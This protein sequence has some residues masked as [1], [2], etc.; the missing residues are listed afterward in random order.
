MTDN[1]NLPAQVDGAAVVTDVVRRQLPTLADVVPA[2]FNE[3]RFGRLVVSAA[4]A[5]PQLMECF[6]TEAG[7]TS[8]A[9]AAIQ[10]AA[11]GLEP[12]TPLQEA[13]LLPQRNKDVQECRLQIGYKGL[14]KLARNNPDVKEIYAKVVYAND[15]FDYVYGLNPTLTHKPTKGDKGKLKFAYGVVK[16]HSGG[17]DFVVLDEADIAKRKE[18]SR[19]SSSPSSPW[20]KWEAEMW[21][22]SAL[23]RVL[24]TAVSSPDLAQALA[25]DEQRLA[26]NN[27]TIVAALDA[28]S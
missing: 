28:G 10:A 4:K 9:L 19:G 18:A 1:N 22:K 21:Q 27:G 6:A 7:Q 3:K 2:N 24:A 16:F 25:V 20:Q 17:A 14:L 8:V 23:R 13:W 26:V 5:T 11:L 15:A 12:N